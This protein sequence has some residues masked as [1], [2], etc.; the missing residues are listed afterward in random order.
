MQSIAA[1]F[2]NCRHTTDKVHITVQKR[3]LDAM[4]Q[5]GIICFMEFVIIM[6]CC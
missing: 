1:N 4:K 5:S 6:Q 2:V 3:V